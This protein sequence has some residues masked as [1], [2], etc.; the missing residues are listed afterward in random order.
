MNKRKKIILEISEHPIILEK[1]VPYLTDEVIEAFK[2]MFSANDDYIKHLDRLRKFRNFAA[3]VIEANPSMHDKLFPLFET[4]NK[5]TGL[6]MLN[7]AV[8]EVLPASNVL[9]LS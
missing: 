5:L 7:S 6:L 4:V 3:D 2:R 1:E 8:H 9:T